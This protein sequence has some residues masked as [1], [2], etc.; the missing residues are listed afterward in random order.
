MP[1][2]STRPAASSRV[3]GMPGTGPLELVRSRP[4]SAGVGATIDERRAVTTT[5]QRCNR[6]VPL[7]NRYHRPSV[8]PLRQ[9][10]TDPFVPSQAPRVARREKSEWIV[11]DTG[12]LDWLGVRTDSE[13]GCPHVP[14]RYDGATLAEFE[15]SSKATALARRAVD[16]LIT[17]D[18]RSLL[19]SGPV[20]CGKP[21]WLRL[22]ATPSRSRS[23]KPCRSL[24]RSSRA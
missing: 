3:P 7:P 14:L 23:S 20:G 19:L 17:H 9:S 12:E 18:V 10:R 5:S 1:S 11:P 16:R 2:S 4:A 22:H 21:T 15:T 24:R 13:I 8:R 6:A